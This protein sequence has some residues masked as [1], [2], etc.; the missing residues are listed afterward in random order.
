MYGK[1][2]VLLG[3]CDIAL[4]FFSHVVIHV[5]FADLQ[6]TN[7]TALKSAGLPALLLLFFLNNLIY[8]RLPA[9]SCF[10]FNLLQAHFHVSLARPAAL[11]VLPPA[12]SCSS[13]YAFRERQQ[14]QFSFRVLYNWLL[15][16]CAACSKP[17]QRYCGRMRVD[18]VVTWWFSGLH[19]FC[20]CPQRVGTLLQM[21]EEIMFDLCLPP[22][23]LPSRPLGPLCGFLFFLNVYGS[24]SLF[25]FHVKL[26]LFHVLRHCEN[27][28]LMCLFLCDLDCWIRF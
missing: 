6:E 15:Y 10:S 3:W 27:M 16:N 8:L 26:I 25:S 9:S 23:R 2:N 5:N 7:E 13:L 28:I 19:P 4:L 22:S 14:A 21:L 12:S 1:L 18:I 24:V 20:L 11:H 17:A